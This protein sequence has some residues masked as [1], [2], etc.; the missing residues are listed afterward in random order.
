MEFPRSRFRNNTGAIIAI[1]LLLSAGAIHSAAAEDCQLKRMASLPITEDAGGRT[2]VPV[3][4]NGTQR[5]FLVDTGGIYSSI[6]ESVSKELKLK[7]ARIRSPVFDSYGR[8]LDRGTIVESL[9][10]GNNQAADINLLVEPDGAG[11]QIAGTLA[12]DLLTLFD[13]DF[14]YQSKKLNLFSP[15]HCEGKVVYWSNSYTDASFSLVDGYHIQLEVML[16]GHS[17]DAYVDTGAS[18]TIM[19]EQAASRHYGL[20]AASANAEKI[21]G[22]QPVA[23]YR[24]RFSSLTLS[25]ISVRNPLV[26]IVADAA[27]Q[28]AMKDASKGDRD[29]V[30]GRALR[31]PQLILGANVLRQLHLYIAYKEHKIYATA[32]AAHL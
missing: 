26:Y 6:A 13:L 15:Q 30:Y 28:A 1:T 19:M 4:I 32:A 2:F 3:G 5:L 25:G 16:D 21:E 31:G 18:S 29:P 14:D 17:L 8:K 22:G 11:T 24:Y 20:S 12:P 23:R 27:S 7:S 9:M 10:L